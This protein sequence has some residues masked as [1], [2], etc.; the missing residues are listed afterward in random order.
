MNNFSED[1]KKQFFIELDVFR[2]PLRLSHC[3]E[4]QN[5]LKMYWLGDF[6]LFAWWKRNHHYIVSGN[7]S[8]VSVAIMLNLLSLILKG[9]FR[10]GLAV[11]ISCSIFNTYSLLPLQLKTNVTSCFDKTFFVVFDSF[12]QYIDQKLKVRLV[13]SVKYYERLYKKLD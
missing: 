10:K 4:V 13:W 3:D 7:K 2:Y 1:I 12:F 8:A 6:W 9:K 11:S 5:L